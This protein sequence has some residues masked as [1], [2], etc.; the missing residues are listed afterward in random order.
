MYSSTTLAVNSTQCSKGPVNIYRRRSRCFSGG[1]TFFQ[2]AGGGG[3]VKLFDPSKRGGGVRF[4]FA[5]EEGGSS[6]FLPRPEGE[7]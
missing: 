3:D 2:G 1:S 4:V 6:L 5:F 7:S